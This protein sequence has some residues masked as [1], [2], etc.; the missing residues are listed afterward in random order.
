MPDTQTKSPQTSH[1]RS[2]RLVQGVVILRIAGL[3]K[4][5][6]TIRNESGQ[7]L[8]A[9]SLVPVDDLSVGDEVAV[10]FEAGDP[11]R[12]VIMGRMAHQRTEAPTLDPSADPF[13]V[14]TGAEQTVIS[15]PRKLRLKCGK[16]A[17]TLT[18]DGRVELSGDYVL[19]TA[20]GT[21]RIAGASV[22]IN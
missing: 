8:N 16:A 12:P 4:T 11:G 10:M 17:I 19:S 13:V 2:E 3:T 1:A 20:K 15:H 6:A 7:D 5:A 22:K 21:N 14:T 18:A 9:A